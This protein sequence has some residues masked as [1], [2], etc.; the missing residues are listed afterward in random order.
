M[1]KTPCLWSGGLYAK[2]PPSKSVMGL[3][4]QVSVMTM[5]SMLDEFMWL[6]ILRSFES[7]HENAF[8]VAICTL[9]IY[10]EI[11]SAFYF[12]DAVCSV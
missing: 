7:V 6:T 8:S 1:I 3:L 11:L 2:N 10:L 4:I 5:M 9:T 12:N